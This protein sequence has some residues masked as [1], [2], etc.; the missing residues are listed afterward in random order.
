MNISLS[1]IYQ[2]YLFEY[3]IN[4]Q[5]KIVLENWWRQTP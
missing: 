1:Y 3:I 2:I 4:L 5:N